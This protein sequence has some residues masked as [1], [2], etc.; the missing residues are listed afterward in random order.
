VS[1]GN[2]PIRYSEA[3]A[4][5]DVTLWQGAAPTR[6]FA[7][8]L[9]VWRVE[10]RA[11]VT[12]GEDYA[13]IDRFLERGIALAGLDTPAALAD[14]LGLDEVVVDRALRFLAA[15][16][17]LARQ[18]GGLMLTDLGQR[19]VRDD[20]RY[21]VTR[22]DRRVLYFDAFGSRPLTSPYYDP[23]VTLLS[24][25]QAQAVAAAGEWPRFRPLSSTH[26]FRPE[27]LAELARHPERQRFN[28]P[29]RVDGPE[30]LGAAEQMF[31]PMYLVRATQPDQRVRLFAYTQAGDTADLDVSEIC[32]RTPEISSLIE[33]EE[34]SAPDFP[35]KA[36][37]WLEGLNLGAY[38]PERLAGGAWRVTLPG[39]AFGGGAALSLVM[40]G[41]FVVRDRDVLNVWC[42]DAGIRRQAFLE[43]VD[44]YLSYRARPEGAG[45]EALIG[46]LARLLDL[47]E[48][49]VPEL[50]QMAVQAGKSGLAAQLAS[51][52]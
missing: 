30:V 4:L 47:G 48:V 50:R 33:T 39:S 52:S 7:I 10:I 23:A 5:E 6:I 36:A 20:R 8:L 49:G 13:L 44:A 19:S 24:P 1:G 51:L 45:T 12:Q 11:T 27:A 9:P 25:G 38:R 3:R 40:A 43:R 42:E 2:N 17:H 31:L 15:I 14:F 37:R 28:L 21:I 34:A 18:D 26:G 41:S 29:E 22:Q 35:G 46:Q 16:G 32:E